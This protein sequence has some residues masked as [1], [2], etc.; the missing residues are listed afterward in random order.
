M[1]IFNPDGSEVD[2]CGNGS[3]CVALY[4]VKEKICG[5]KMVIE[6]RAGN[7]QATVKQDRI[8]IKMSNPF[9]LRL[10]FNLDING[11]TQNVNYV[12]TGVPH[13]VCFVQGLDDFNV[14]ETGRAI[15]YHPEFQPEGTNANFVQVLDKDH[16]RLRTYERGVEQ[17]TLA[18]GTGAVA[19][20]IIT[21][22]QMEKPQGRYRIKVDTQG[23]EPLTVYFNIKNSNIDEVFL[24]GEAKIVY[25][26]KRE[27]LDV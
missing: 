12:N 6:T 11:R 20:S 27:A 2:M 9:D 1:R 13:L 7:L 15:R 17:E 24:E 3:R 8:K 16:I 10:K 4:A 25:K 19:A 18:C 22:C 21:T 14:Q 23:G 26:A 5:N